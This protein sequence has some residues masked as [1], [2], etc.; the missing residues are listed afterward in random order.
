MLI[1]QDRKCR[2]SEIIRKRQGPKH[3]SVRPQPLGQLAIWQSCPREGGKRGGLDA[4]E[5]PNLSDK[6]IN[7]PNP[8]RNC[9]HVAPFC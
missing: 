6:Y 3:I 5:N 1:S 9:S 8:W 2:K 4:K 7:Q